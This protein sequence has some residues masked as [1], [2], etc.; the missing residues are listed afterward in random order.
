MEPSNF[1]ERFVV[2]CDVLRFVEQLLKRRS[3]QMLF[4]RL[5]SVLRNDDIEVDHEI[6]HTGREIG[7]PEE[8]RIDLRRVLDFEHLDDGI[9]VQPDDVD[10]LDKFGRLFGQSSKREGVDTTLAERPTVD[11][12]TAVVPSDEYVVLMSPSELDECVLDFQVVSYR[13]G[14]ILVVGQTLIVRRF[15][16]PL[17][18]VFNTGWCRLWTRRCRR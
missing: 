11:R 7:H 2:D 3:G 16:L 14:F 12:L 5:R 9:A 13:T 1:G 18:R 17:L 4:S 10:I 15:L 6:R 8:S